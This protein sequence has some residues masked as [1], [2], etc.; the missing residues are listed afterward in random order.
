MRNNEAI[1][2]N[3][4][5]YDSLLKAFEEIQKV[6]YGLETYLSSD[7]MALDIREAFYHFG[8]ITEQ[9]TNVELLGNILRISVS[10]SNRTEQNRTKHHKTKQNKT[11]AICQIIII[12]NTL[13]YLHLCFILDI[14]RCFD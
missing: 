14:M 4:K 13:T 3:T 7:L 8:M 11:S 12:I 5:H 1:V 10:K 9:V 2:T 6:K